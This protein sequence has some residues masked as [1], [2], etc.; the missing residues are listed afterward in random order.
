VSPETLFGEITIPVRTFRCRGCGGRGGVGRRRVGPAGGDRH[1]WGHG[2]HRRAL[3][4]SG[5]CGAVG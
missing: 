5:G 1:G 4:G 2:P 3:A